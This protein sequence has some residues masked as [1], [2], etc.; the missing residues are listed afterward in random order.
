MKGP[1]RANFDGTLPDAPLDCNGYDELPHENVGHFPT[2]NDIDLSSIIQKEIAKY[3]K[4][5]G[6]STQALFAQTN[7]ACNRHSSSIQLEKGS[8]I[9]DTR[10]SN[11]MCHDLNLFDEITNTNPPLLVFLLDGSTHLVHKTGRVTFSK[12]ISLTSVLY[13]PSF[14]FNLLSVHALYASTNLSFSFSSVSCSLQDPKT[15]EVLVVGKVV[16]TLCILDHIV[17][18][19]IRLTSVALNVHSTAPICTKHP[20]MKKDAKFVSL[21]HK[22]FDHALTKP[23]KHIS[24]LSEIA[25]SDF[26]KYDV[27]PLAKQSRLP[28]Y[29]RVTHTN[30]VFE[31]IHVDLWGGTLSA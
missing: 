18:P 23:L 29:P 31:L 14:N 2:S 6:C 7:F 30:F 25:F 12:D 8:W 11:H 4:D 1:V 21:W 15:R 3:L 10:A 9:I 24:F 16:G 22:R 19:T 27:C 17:A 28:F 13:L 5:K 26:T 20:H